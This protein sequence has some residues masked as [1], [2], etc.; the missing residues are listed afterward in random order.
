MANTGLARVQHD[1]YSGTVTA[2]RH[3]RRLHYE[4]IG[5]VLAHSMDERS[6]RQVRSAFLGFYPAAPKDPA[7]LIY[8]SKIYDQAALKKMG[9]PEPARRSHYELR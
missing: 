1:H 6:L 2:L 5:L 8:T 3:L 7:K 4:R 9:H